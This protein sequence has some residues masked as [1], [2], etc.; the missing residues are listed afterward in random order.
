MGGE[1]E[2]ERRGEVDGESGEEGKGGEGGEGAE[3]EVDME[4]SELVCLKVALSQQVQRL[5]D[6]CASEGER[7]GEEEERERKVA[8][9]QVSAMARKL[10]DLQRQVSMIVM[11]V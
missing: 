1:N 8:A 2:E 4:S 7:V 5:R 6:L 3:G 11:A 10:Y 9:A